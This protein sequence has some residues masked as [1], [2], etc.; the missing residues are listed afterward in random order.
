MSASMHGASVVRVLSD[1]EALRRSLRMY[2]PS[3]PS[4]EP[5]RQRLRERTLALAGGAESGSVSFGPS[6]LFWNGEEVDLP[7][8][9]PAARLVTLLF[10]LG[11]A[12][13][14]L[15]FPQAADGLVQLA[16]R[17]AGLNDPPGEADRARLLAEGDEPA[18]V[19]LVPI[20]L[21]GVHLSGSGEAPEVAGARPVWAELA[22]RLSRDGSFPLAG[23]IREGELNPGAVVGLLAETPD[24]ETL[25]DHLFRQLAEIVAAATGPRAPVALAEVREFFAELVRLLDPERATLAVVS[26]LRHLPLV[27]GDDPWV[28][29]ELLLD[30]VERMLLHGFPIP[31][32]VQRAL[33]RLA[34][35]ASDRSAGVPDEVVARARHLLAAIPS[36]QALE[37]SRPSPPVPSPIDLGDTPPAREL[38][39]ALGEGDVRLHLVR[40]LQEAIML[41]PGEP[42]AERAAVRLAEEFAT[43]LELGDVETAVRLAPVLAVTRS[44]EARAVVNE[45]GV[46]AAVQAF[47][48]YDRRHHPDLTAILCALGET[49][50]PAVLTALAE[51]DSLAVRKRLLEVVA[52]QGKRALPYLEPLL[53]DPR[54]FVVRNAVFLLRRIGG[55]EAAPLLKARVTGAAPKVLLEILKALVAM[56]DPAWLATLTAEIDSPDEERRRV[57]LDVASH[58]RH[59]DV[60]RIVIE[61]LRS[62]IGNRLRDPFSLDLI[63]ALGRLRDPAALPALREILGLKQWRYAFPLDAARRESAAAIAR[64]EGPD[65]RKAAMELARGRD[66]DVAGAVQAAFHGRGEAAEDEL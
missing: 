37:A 48:T 14:R 11:L 3:H 60:V 2:P 52:R 50:L 25:F 21:S 42:V 46:P 26:G 59:P 6:Q 28:A 13:V 4:L 58:I 38:C 51:E 56:Q 34:A 8:A 36:S 47:R 66:A 33:H 39:A 9:A 57:A 40:L 55:S 20:D 15:T 44:P 65:A 1:L 30:A 53:D 19:E 41:W 32:Q 63:R 27:G 49:A 10:H 45:S 16:T 12:A 54:W 7:D 64:L 35:P 18:G 31:E 62:R 5:A 61:R 24:A 29:A 23:R 43:S 17:L 22:R